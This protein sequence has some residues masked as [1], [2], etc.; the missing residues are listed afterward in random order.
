MKTKTSPAAYVLL[1]LLIAITLAYQLAGS[2]SQIDSLFDLRKHARHPFELDFNNFAISQVYPEAQTA[3]LAKGDVVDELDGR[4]LS[5]VYRWREI[6]WYEHPGEVLRVNAHTQG[7]KTKDTNILLQRPSSRPSFAE[8]AVII[9]LRIVIP[10]FCLLLGYWVVLARP[11]DRNA[12]FIFVLLA[13]P[14]SFSA[15]SSAIWW[16]GW[17]LTLRVVW[18]LTLEAAGPIA[19]LWFGF[20]FPERSRFDFRFPWVKWVISVS[21]LL[22]LATAFWTDYGE[23]YD[24]AAVP[25][26]SQ[27]DLVNSYVWSTLT[28]CCLPFYALAVIDK[29]RSASTADA[30]RRMRVLTAG[31]AVGIGSALVIWT[32]LPYFGVEPE[33]LQW[34][35]Y[36]SA[37]LFLTFPLSLAYVIIVQRALDVR[38]LL[39]IGTKYALARTTLLIIEF[40]LAIVLIY[41]FIVPVFGREHKHVWD[42]L[43][44][45]AAF[46]VLIWL[47]ALRGSVSSRLQNWLDRKFFREA[48]NAELLLTELAEQARRYKEPQTL[49]NTVASRI[50]EALHVP[51]IAVFLRNGER[52]Q[53]QQAIGLNLP[54]H[55][56]IPANLA[57]PRAGT[58]NGHSEISK[59]AQQLLTETNA[60]VVLPLQGRERLMGLMTLGPKQSEEAYSASDLRLLGSVGTQTGLGLEI[61]ELA[62][63]LAEEAAQRQRIVRELE[64]AR[65]VQ[66]RLFP[67]QI[68][69]RDGIDLAGY[70]RPA[71]GVGGDYYDMIDFEDGRLGLAIGDVSGKGISAALL[72]A[73]LRASLRGMATDNPG[74]LAPLM[75]K[76]NRLVYES[77]AANRYATF[78]FATYQPQTRE[79]RYVN[80]GHNPPI[81]LRCSG[82]GREVLRL[83]AGGPVIGLLRDL[84][85]TEQTLRLQAGDIL[86]GY[87]DG[88]SEAMTTEDEEWGEERMLGAAEAACNKPASEIIGRIFAAADDFT[89]GATQ[90]DDMTL[91]VMKVTAPR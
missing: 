43:L 88:I 56:E 9:F 59:P 73:S 81:V 45:L 5:G 55:I 47:F 25:W 76:L 70:C 71:L 10:F 37:L 3:G 33:K 44:S 39:R 2:V 78:F 42:V 83:E 49:L 51:Q 79:L 48:Y 8:S 27:V 20:Y 38:I 87:T 57:V 19:L 80:A 32:I 89:A 77:S 22:C 66:Q 86:I 82:Q 84:A 60:E 75:K 54:A 24:R 41:Y 50:S 91:L 26:R 1:F 35:V 46:T 90:H 34:L 15:V 63:S 16:P 62:N 17:W 40:V 67:Q 28:V 4:A 23:W 7:G 72:M 52:F 18:H 65:E 36:T 69:V 30:R 31:S 64:I 21:I 85:Y 58:R 11:W 53:L 74:H 12:W 14:Q 29:L 13:F 68:P 61:T 6:T